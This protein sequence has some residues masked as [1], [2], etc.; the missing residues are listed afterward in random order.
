MLVLSSIFSFATHSESTRSRSSPLREHAAIWLRRLGKLLA[1]VNATWIVLVCLF[2][3]TGVYDTCWCNSSVLYLGKHAYSVWIFTP[4]D[5]AAFWY[6]VVGGTVLARLVGCA[7]LFE[8][9]I[10]LREFSFW[11]FSGVVIIFIAFV[12]LLLEP[13]LSS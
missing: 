8:S 10:E 12:N 7:L 13:H 11:L 4:A 3:F 1:A 6:P 2:Q 5:I 9:T